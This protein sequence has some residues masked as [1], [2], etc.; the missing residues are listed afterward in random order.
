M[1]M[2]EKW[3]STDKSTRAFQG[4]MESEKYPRKDS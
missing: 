2:L 4:K 3:C 1:E